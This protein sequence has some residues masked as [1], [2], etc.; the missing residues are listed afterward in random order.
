[1]SE[2]LNNYWIKTS[3]DT[4]LQRTN[5]PAD[6]K[7]VEWTDL[8]SYTLALYRGA[9]ALE[10]DVYDGSDGPVVRPGKSSFPDETANSNDTISSSPFSG[11]SLVFADVILTVKYFLQSEPNSLPI[12]LLIENH[13]SLLQQEKM[14]SVIENVLGTSNLLYRP[15][16]ADDSS[17]PSPAELVGKV[18][19]KSKRLEKVTVGATVLNDDF[20]DEIRTAVPLSVSGYDSEDDLDK[21]IIGFTSAG[22]IKAKSTKGLTLKQLFLTAKSEAKEATTAAEDAKSQ[23]ADVKISSLQAQKHAD[24]LLRDIG[25]TYEEIK[26]KRESGYGDALNEGTEVELFGDGARVKENANRALEIAKAFAESVEDFRLLSIAANTEARSETELYEIAR[27]ELTE[28]ET[29]L[30]EAKEAL[31]EISKRNYELSE[32]AERALADAR[33]NREYADNAE[34]RVAAV[35]ALLNKSQHQANSSETVSGTADA[36]AKIS[37]QRARD[38]EARAKKARSSANDERAKADKETK[39]EDDLETQL[40]S[41]QNELKESKK[42]VSAARERANDAVSKAEELT[43]EIRQVKASPR[44]SQMST[45]FDEEAS[46]ASS[47]L[48]NKMSEERKAYIGQMEDA[49]TDKLSREAKTRKLV[50]S[51]DDLQRKVKLQAKIAASARR[52]ADHSMASAEQ[53]EVSLPLCIQF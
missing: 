34:S 37:E 11:A 31:Q 45:T 28:K 5:A 38:A 4:F 10:L 6:K 43:D 48:T 29:I 23:L 36:E 40:A 2:P 30:A 52:Q 46:L 39:L 18:I 51:I 19:I 24:A 27:E 53:L 20:D 3:H 16:P 26:K 7:R 8:Q 42:A 35:R 9:R 1:M 21:D 47:A 13:C 25:M 14:A 49:L 17:L 41:A 50:T 12:I 33:S 15:Q 22:S 44:Y 32:A